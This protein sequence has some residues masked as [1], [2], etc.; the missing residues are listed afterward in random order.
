[1]SEQ[2]L[3]SLEDIRYIQRYL[4][5]IRAVDP[6]EIVTVANAHRFNELNQLIDIKLFKTLT[7]EILAE[8]N[9]EVGVT[10][11]PILLERYLFGVPE[12]EMLGGFHDARSVGYNYWLQAGFVMLL[13]DRMVA[14]LV[15]RTIETIRNYLHDCMHHATF[16]TFR[17]AVRVPAMSRDF[18]KNRVPEIYREQY[19]INFRNRDGYSYSQPELT[20]LSPQAINLNLL[21]DGTIVLTIARLMRKKVSA[22]G[23]MARSETERFI[24][25]EFFLEDPEFVDQYHPV[26]RQY[27]QNIVIPTSRFIAHWGGEELRIRIVRAMYTGRLGARQYRHSMAD[28][29]VHRGLDI[30]ITPGATVRA[31]I[32]G[33]LS[34]S[35]DAIETANAVEIRGRS[36]IARYM[37]L[38]IKPTLHEGQYIRKGQ[39]L[40][41]VV[42]PPNESDI[43]YAEVGGSTVHLHLEISRQLKNDESP[44][45]S[46]VIGN[47]VYLNHLY[48]SKIGNL[49]LPI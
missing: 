14:S 44:E 4:S 41:Q 36:L 43:R 47:H 49:P 37:H 39:I 48:L 30:Y 22:I 38:K 42:L 20:K 46:I 27:V 7:A 40:G 17:R 24:V 2:Y 31:T 34:S 28:R 15:I 9:R 19:G 32:G 1:M 6:I 33:I 35:I 11:E 21:M 16:R 23:L 5:A 29:L 13:N 12:S 45:G 26:S 10:A 18:A 25:N 3:G 8:I